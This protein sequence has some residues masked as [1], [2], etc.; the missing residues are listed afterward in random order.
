MELRGSEVA[1]EQPLL[2]LLDLEPIDE[3]HDPDAQR[4]AL[5]RRQ[6]VRLAEAIEHADRALDLGDR[7]PR[8]AAAAHAPLGEH[9]ALVRDPLTAQRQ[10]Q[11][12]LEILPAA[13]RFVEEPGFDDRVASRD[14]RRENDDAAL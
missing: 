1:L 6:I 12:Q 13:D 14:D 8:E 7:G 9:V 3:L 4:R 5:A 2:R 11:P 10:P